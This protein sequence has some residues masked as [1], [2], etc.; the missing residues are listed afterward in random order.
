M[1]AAIHRKHKPVTFSSMYVY[2][3]LIA[4]S[5]PMS[6]IIVNI[7]DTTASLSWMPPEMP[8]GIITQYQV[9]YSKSDSSSDFNSSNNSNT[10]LTYTV[11]ELLSNT[12][13]VFRVRAFTIVGHGPSSNEVIRYTSKSD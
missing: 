5:A 3:F 1:C 12:E 8:N 13:Y 4:P 2:C 9:Q 7:T 6:L 11:T 10:N